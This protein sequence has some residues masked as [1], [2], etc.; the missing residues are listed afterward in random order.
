MDI[1]LVPGSLRTLGHFCKQFL[2]SIPSGAGE[3]GA[4]PRDG[5][6]NECLAVL[7]FPYPDGLLLT[8]F[9]RILVER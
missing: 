2:E 4:V 7:L 8:F 3:H 5:G 1:Q 6:G 9:R